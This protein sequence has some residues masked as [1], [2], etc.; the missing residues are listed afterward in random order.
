MRALWIFALACGC[1]SHALGAGSDGAAADLSH[2]AAMD[3]AGVDLSGAHDLA[4]SLPDL[5]SAPA[6]DLKGA[7]CTMISAATQQYLDDHVACQND[8]DCVETTTHCGQPGQCGA[9]LQMSALPGLMSIEDAWTN[10]GCM[11]PCPPCA[12]PRPAVCSMGSCVA[13]N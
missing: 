13:G 4:M 1:N 9:Y 6:P 12:A 8:N 11:G 7:S 10:A 5:A 2:A 3:L